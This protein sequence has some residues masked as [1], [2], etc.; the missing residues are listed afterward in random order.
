MKPVS[1]APLADEPRLDAPARRP[2]RRARWYFAIESDDQCGA[3]TKPTSAS[4]PSSSPALDGACDPRLPVAH[5]GQ[6]ADPERLLERGAD[7]LRHG[8]ERRR[9]VRVVDPEAA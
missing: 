4:W 1:V 2:C 3:R 6:H 9:P 5:A 8:V 7:L